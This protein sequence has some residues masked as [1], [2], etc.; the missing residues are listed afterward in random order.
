MRV[1]YSYILKNQKIKIAY[2]EKIHIRLKRLL[3]ISYCI[4]NS[5]DYFF[6]K[7]KKKYRFNI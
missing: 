1:W 6:Y 4:S 2:K 7:F 3:L 5:C